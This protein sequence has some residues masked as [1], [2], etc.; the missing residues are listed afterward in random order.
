MPIVL[1]PYQIEAKNLIRAS[2]KNGN[3]SILYVAPC[4][5]GKTTIFSDLASTITANGKRVFLITH[6]DEL[7]TQVSDTLKLFGVDHGFIQSGKFMDYK[8]LAHVCSVQTLSRRLGKISFKPSV[9]IVDESHHSCSASYKKI[10]SAYPT[11][12]IGVTAT[13]QR[14][15]GKGLGEVFENLIIG[16]TMAQL[17]AEGWLS[18]YKL[19]APSLIDTSKLHTR[20]GDFAIDEASKAADKPK[21][22]GD[23][24]AH[25]KK[26]ADGLRAVVYCCSVEHA[27]HTA[28][29][30]SAA[31]YKAA[32]IDGGM[33]ADLRHTVVKAFRQGGITILTS[34]EIVSE[35]FDL[36]AIECAIFLRPTQSLSMWIQMSGRALR[37]MEG[38]KVAVL[39][40]H[41]G[42]C[43]RLGFPDDDRNWSL[44][45]AERAGSGAS[46][47]GVRICPKCLLAQRPGLEAC[48]SCKYVWPVKSRQVDTVD[49]ELVEAAPEI[50]PA[51]KHEFFKEMNVKEIHDW[52]IK[53]GY[54]ETKA[55]RFAYFIR[56]ER[57]KHKLA[58]GVAA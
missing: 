16:P 47:P 19:Y 14:L 2:M 7:I 53:K 28:D 57:Q 38:K 50:I 15:D 22:T 40:D 27:K 23:A 6:R 30:F 56:Q 1:R 33:D 58:Q 9:I 11:W 10:F 42:N 49:G 34:C 17:I 20:L 52:A 4:A 21:I 48:P 46:K 39:L 36:P 43:Q 41:A 24:I 26:Y 32:S 8:P 44:A 13:P 25:Y 3:K 18:P 51:G 5:S 29:Q 55:W 12:R 35:G 54:Q 31:G 37:I 45:G